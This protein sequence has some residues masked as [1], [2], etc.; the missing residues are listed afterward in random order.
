[1][2][3]AHLKEKWKSGRTEITDISFSSI[4]RRLHNEELYNLYASSILIRV[5]KSRRMR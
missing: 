1:M 5:I 4:W 2:L 3:D